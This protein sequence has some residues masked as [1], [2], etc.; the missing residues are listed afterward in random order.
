MSLELTHTT[1]LPF[2]GVQPR[3][4]LKL[5]LNTQ[6]DALTHI[7]PLS[8]RPNLKVRF[9]SANAFDAGQLLI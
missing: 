3:L 6:N 2:T 4:R 1:V 5:T 9:Q 7:K 8:E